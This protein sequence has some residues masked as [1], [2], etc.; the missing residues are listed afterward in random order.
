MTIPAAIPQTMTTMEGGNILAAGAEDEFWNVLESMYPIVASQPGFLSVTAGPIANSSWSYASAK[1]ATPDDA[2]RWYHNHQHQPVMRKARTTWFDAY[3][4]RKWRLPADGEELTGPLLCE[5]V[6]VPPAALDVPTLDTVVASLSEALTQYEA[7]PFETLPGQFEQ[8]PFQFIGPVKG[9]PED[10]APVRY[11]L[12]SQWADPGELTAWLGSADYTAL[13]RLGAVTNQVTML[14]RH[15]V[16]ERE[17]LNANG[18]LRGWSRH[19]ALG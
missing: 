5:T 2:D 10:T 13:G 11:L 7:M 4:L 6:I 8:Q 19:T 17:G 12:I 14:V 3:Y 15:Q 9:F 18:S 1:F 16:G